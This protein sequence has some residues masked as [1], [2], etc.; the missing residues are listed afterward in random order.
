MPF[1][2]PP[3]HLNYPIALYTLDTRTRDYRMS[4]R[5]LMGLYWAMGSYGV[6]R[7]GCGVDQRIMK[8]GEVLG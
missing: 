1:V 6:L 4:Q 3:L 2:N 8:R 7:R 5:L